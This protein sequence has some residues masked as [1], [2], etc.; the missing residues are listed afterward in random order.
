MAEFF[1][2]DDVTKEFDSTISRRILSYLKP[3]RRITLFAFF[4]L[5]VST[6]GELLSPVIIRRTIDGALMQSWYGVARELK[7]SDMAKPLKLS[8][9][10]PLVGGKIYIKAS[11]IS[12]ISAAERRELAARG[13][14][15]SAETYLFEVDEK[16]EAQ[17]LLLDKKAELFHTEGRW[18]TISVE[19]LRALPSDEAAVLRKADRLLIRD[20][21]LLFLAILF[22]ILLSTFAM[23]YFSNLLGLKVM[24]DLRMQLFDHVLSRSFSF[25]SKQ[26]V[27]RL[28]TRLTSDIET[29]SQF[30]SDV[31]SAFI[32]DVSIMTGAIVVLFFFDIRL[33]LV[34]T[35]SVPFVLITSNVARKRARDAFRNQRRW[36]SKVNAY[37]A[38]HLAGID[39]VKLFAKEAKVNAE[40]AKHDA[41]LKKANLGEMYVFATFR[42][43]V[44]FLSTLTAAIAICAGAWFY[45][46]RSISLGTLIAFINLIAMF[47]SPIKDMAEKYIMLQSAMAGGERIFSLLDASETIPD[48]PRLPMPAKIRGHIEFDRVWFAYKEEEWVL[49]D[50]SFTVDPGQM[51]AIVGYTGAGKTTIANLVTRFWDIQK[52]SI[53]VDGHSVS[54]L[55]LQGLRKAI[56]PVPQDVFLFSGSIEENL[57]LGEEV[58]RERMRLAAEAVHANEFIEALPEKYDTLLSEGGS[59][60]S[61][62]QRQLLSFARVLAHDPS[63]IILDEATSS[64]DTET[65]RLIQR[66]IEGLLS[67]RTSIVIAHRL[68]T[69]RHAD[70]IVVLAQGRIAETGRHDELIEKRGLYWNLYRLQNS[71]HV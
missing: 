39:I 69:I 13:L 36:T 16:D 51:V 21:V 34:V 38:E 59:N 62:G 19:K 40:F 26:P 56:Q 15:D 7:D 35:A 3:Y 43:I 10:D 12:A 41:Q 67:G 14:F 4:A 23:V 31:L 46:S 49:K 53:R 71:G 58:T 57:R 61:Q 2:T 20:N 47:Y 33:A 28:V 63:I 70:K 27:G 55:P 25:L 18:G 64:V 42:P 60:L 44:D 29:I 68:S 11:R 48:A 30:F 45:L 50:L 52:G 8:G 54:D 1:D 6:A 32:K 24:N 22:A 66:G 5:V 65:E 17:R 9:E 37:I